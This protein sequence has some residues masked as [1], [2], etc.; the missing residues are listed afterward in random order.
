M[1]TDFGYHRSASHN[2]YPSCNFHN[3]LRL[4]ITM[5]PSLFYSVAT[6]YIQSEEKMEFS[7][8]RTKLSYSE[9]SPKKLNIYMDS[10]RDTVLLL[11]F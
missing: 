7:E 3:K 2:S 9:N 8:I 11:Y 6:Q 4:N 5:A 1:S 10:G